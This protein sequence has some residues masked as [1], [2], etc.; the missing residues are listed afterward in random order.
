MTSASEFYGNAVGTNKRDFVSISVPCTIWET[1]FLMFHILSYFNICFCFI[2]FYYYPLDAHFFSKERQKGGII[3]MGG[4][5]GG[6]ARN[7]RM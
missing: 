7:G 5:V 1:L 2:L 3:L 6:M 4:E